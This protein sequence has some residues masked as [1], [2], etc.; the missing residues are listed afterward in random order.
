ML[1]ERPPLK[2]RE[3]VRSLR[4]TC[5]GMWDGRGALAGCCE[6]SLSSGQGGRCAFRAMKVVTQDNE[7]NSVCRTGRK[8]PSPFLKFHHIRIF[9]SKIL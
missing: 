7:V 2:I 3:E 8:I 6:R 5:D 1:R 9:I 4:M